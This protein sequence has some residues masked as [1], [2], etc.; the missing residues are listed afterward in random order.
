[1]VSRVISRTDK[2][3]RP[4]PIL[5]QR[6]RAVFMRHYVVYTNDLWT[7]AFPTLVEPLIFIVAVGWGL[8]AAVG[9][10]G[11]LDYLSFIAPAQVMMSAV[12]T[13]AFEASYNTYLR[14]HMDHNYD[15]M[16]ST[17]VNVDEVFWGELI[18]IAVK[19][20]FYTAIMLTV[21]SLFHTMHSPLALLVPLVGFFTAM[22]FG[23]LGFFANAIVKSINQFNFF[24]SGVISPLIL[25][26]GT[27]FPIEKLPPVIQQAAYVL[28]LYHFVHLSR[29]LTTGVF[30][31]DWPISLA[32]VVLVPLVMGFFAVR[33]M[34]PKLIQ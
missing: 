23:S 28:P 16:I 12:Y 13:S 14:L 21:L 7:N 24:V 31:P 10:F 9:S 25:F 20:F 2:G 34:R 6:I 15:A 18:F 11:G 19:G 33:A 32:Y 1:M 5:L 4:V 17:P 29:M 8:A 26:S 30:N 3:I 27:L 22:A